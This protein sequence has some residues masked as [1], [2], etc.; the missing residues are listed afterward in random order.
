M[1][2]APRE[3]LTADE[4]LAADRELDGAPEAEVEGRGSAEAPAAEAAPEESSPP[5][6][7]T[8][9]AAP[10]SPAPPRPPARLTVQSSPS[11][12][13]LVD[14]KKRG[15]TPLE[16]TVAPGAHR[17]ELRDP[18][19]GLRRTVKVKLASGE[20]HT[21]SWSPQ[22]GTLT[23]EVVPFGDISVDGKSLGVVSYKSVEVWEGTHAVRVVNEEL[24]RTEERKV[25]VAPGA[26]SKTVIRLQE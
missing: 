1:S 23:V 15:R 11:T 13:V 25:Q 18:A 21:E 24:K 6:A 2:P 19:A 16:L 22:K 17:I 20:R 3:G 26:E 7:E 5:E 8:V 9:G 12:E 4:L 14:G 10:P